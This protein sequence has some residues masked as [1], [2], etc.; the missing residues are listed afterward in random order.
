MVD[1]HTH[2]LYG[3]DDGSGT[4]HALVPV[5]DGLA[6]LHHLLDATSI[7]GHDEFLSL[8]IVIHIVGVY[9]CGVVAG[10]PPH[11]VSIFRVLSADSWRRWLGIP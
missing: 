11:T 4:T 2:I 3:V 7:L 6:M 10:E 8:C 9:S 5:S 1:I